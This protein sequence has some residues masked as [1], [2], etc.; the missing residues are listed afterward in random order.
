MQNLNVTAK[1]SLQM[2]IR[3]IVRFV[4][5][6]NVFFIIVVVVQYFTLFMDFFTDIMKMIHAYYALKEYFVSIS[7]TWD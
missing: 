4:S 7:L 5:V 6:G 1:L 3:Y 2:I